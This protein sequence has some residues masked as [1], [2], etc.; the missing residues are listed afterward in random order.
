MAERFENVDSKI[1]ASLQTT[2]YSTHHAM[3][4]VEQSLK[5]ANQL[6]PKISD[7]ELK[8][9]SYQEELQDG[10]K[11]LKQY[12]IPL[13]SCLQATNTSSGQYIIKLGQNTKPFE[14]FC[15]QTKFGGGWTVFQHRFDGSVDFYRNWA[16]YRDGFG[17]VDGEFWLGLENIHQ[18]TKNRPHELIVEVRD[19]E[20]NY[21]YARYGVFEIGS[22]AEGYNLKK[23]RTYSGTAG[24]AMSYN[25][26]HK[27]STFDRNNDLSSDNCAVERHGAWWYNG[28]TIANLNGRYLNT[29]NDRSAIEWRYF[30]SDSR[31]MS[32]S[33]M[34]IRETIK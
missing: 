27:F 31:G 29:Q 15:E 24:D 10:L 3:K 32:Y 33:R 7:L 11:Q 34:M 28:C 8:Q 30:K 6:V 4:Q 25:N 1:E 18:M 22:E 21:G 14:V 13:R 2:E 5:T 26:G 12:I 16:E 23:L 17:S 19:F 20:G 9:M